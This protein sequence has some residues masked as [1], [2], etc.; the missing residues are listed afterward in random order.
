MIPK[1]IA[2]NIQPNHVL[3]IVYENSEKKLFSIVPYLNY[4]VY[5]P[6]KNINFFNQVK[7]KHGTITWGN[8]EM[9]DFDP[10]TIYFEGQTLA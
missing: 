8:D 4:T 6:L 2:V 9:I 5:Q 10:Y 1:I 7:L 3:E